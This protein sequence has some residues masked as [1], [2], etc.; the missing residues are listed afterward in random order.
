MHNITV[1]RAKLWCVSVASSL[2]FTVA[3]HADVSL[4]PVNDPKSGIAG[5]KLFQIDEKDKDADWFLPLND[6]R[7]HS[8]NDEQSMKPDAP[9]LG[10]QLEGENWALPWAP[11]RRHHVANL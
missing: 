4:V 9:I 11:M 7:W 10:L 2:L 8:Y 1:N 3:A 6:F 5:A